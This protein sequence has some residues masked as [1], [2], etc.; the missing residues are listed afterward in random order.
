MGWAFALVGALVGVVQ[1]HLLARSTT[2]GPGLFSYAVRLI[3]VGAVLLIAARS[4]HLAS[5]ACGWILGFAVGMAI[6]LRWVK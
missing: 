5:A 6:Q 1:T 4:G 2:R 3:L